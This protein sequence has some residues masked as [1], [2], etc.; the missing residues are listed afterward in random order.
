VCKC[1]LVSVHACQ[2]LPLRV[3]VHASEQ[4]LVFAHTV[5]DGGEGHCGLW[6]IPAI[7]QDLSQ[8]SLKTPQSRCLPLYIHRAQNVYRFL[9]GHCLEDLPDL[10]HH[11]CVTRASAS[12]MAAVDPDAVAAAAVGKRGGVKVGNCTGGGCPVVSAAAAAVGMNQ[13]IAVGCDKGGGGGDRGTA[14]CAGGGTGGESGGEGG[15]GVETCA[16]A[17]KLP[18]VWSSG[19]PLYCCCCS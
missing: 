13:D 2:G 4:G 6:A 15:G 14:A 17:P 16:D 3:C 10:T 7:L 11:T 18:L 12:A 19:P 8:Q 5:T 1:V 9:R